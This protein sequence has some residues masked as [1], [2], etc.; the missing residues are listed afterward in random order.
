MPKDD[1]GNVFVKG[2]NR[3]LAD[4]LYLFDSLDQKH[5]HPKAKDR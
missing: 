4:R 3:F 2:N 1:R 5:I